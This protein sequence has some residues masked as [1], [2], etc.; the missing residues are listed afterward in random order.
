MKKI[1]KK[2]SNV[3]MV[4][5]LLAGIGFLSYP[6]ISNWIAQQS[7]NSEIQTYTASLDPEK[8]A[9]ALEEA[10]DYNR[11]LAA[12]GGRLPVDAFTEK[13]E[14]L[15]RGYSDML[16]LSDNDVMGFIEIPI[17]N[18]TL[19][20]YHGT[21]EEVLQIGAG[22]L[23]GT[24]LPVGAED[25]TPTHAVLAAHSGLPNAFMFDH[26]DQLDYGD[27][28]K[29]TVAGKELWYEVEQI[30]VVVPSDTS[31][32]VMVESGDYVTLV[33]CT[34]YGVNSHRLLVRGMRGDGPPPEYLDSIDGNNLLA[35][36][37]IVAGIAAAI[38]VITI[39]ITI[40]GMRKNR[41]RPVH[42]R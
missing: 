26:L 14:G 23:Q 1:G 39:F 29:I 4:L 17:I 12:Y 15:D 34:P 10:Y 37:L 11:Q 5:V 22:H 20:I 33:T 41:K 27:W 16:D 28:F 6:A 35:S 9:R 19:P 31:D 8:S 40:R 3:V 42:A 25:A 36:V 38:S 24:S 30:K 2:I 13:G 18:V 21:S 32:L 7:M